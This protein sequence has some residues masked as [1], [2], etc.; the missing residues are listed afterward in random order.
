MAVFS[1]NQNRQFYVAA[2]LADETPSTAGDVQVKSIGEGN[3]KEIYFLYKNLKT[4]EIIKSDR[5]PVK[6]LD[7][8]KVTEAADME[9][10]LK[11]VEIALDSSVN[12]G[13]PI[14]GQDYLIRIVFRQFYGMGDQDQYIKDIVVRASSAT[15]NAKKLFDAF[16]VAAN[17]AF[18]REVGATASGNPY[19]KFE[20]SG[21]GSSG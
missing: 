20:E 14:A 19:L 7:Y 5:I 3:A 16:V 17:K 11:K 4:G 2:A 6:N 15:D 13:A 12:R 8:V 10:P 21:S 18:S 1:V 9:E